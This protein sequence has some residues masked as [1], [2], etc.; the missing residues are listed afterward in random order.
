MLYN[1]GFRFSGSIQQYF[2]QPLDD[3]FIYFQY[4]KQLTHLQF[5]QYNDGDPVSTGATSYLWAVI[6]SIGYFFGFTGSWIIL[7][8]FLI[9]GLF[10]FLTG[11]LLLR[12]GIMIGNIKIGF[13]S[14]LL[15]ILH[16]PIL[17]GL[18]DGLETPLII[19]SFF[20]ALFV[21]LKEEQ[22]GESTYFWTILAGALL[23]L[24]RPEGLIMCAILYVYLLLRTYYKTKSFVSLVKHRI[25]INLILGSIIAFIPIILNLIFTGHISSNTAMSKAVGIYPQVNLYWK[26]QDLINYFFFE[27]KHIFAGYEGTKQDI[28]GNAYGDVTNYFAPYVFLIFILGAFTAMYKEIHNKQFGA[29]GLLAPWF[30]FY[31]II[32]AF[33]MPYNIHWNRYLIPTYP[34][35]FFGAALGACYLSQLSQR[36][37]MQSFIFPGI[38][39]FFLVVGGLNTISFAYT[40]GHNCQ[41]IFNQQ[42]R[43]SKWINENIPENS[44]IAINDAGA[45]KYYTNNYYMYDL[46]GLVTTRAIKPKIN[47]GG[48]VYESIESLPAEELPDYM[49]LLPHW[50]P[51]AFMQPHSEIWRNTLTNA[52]ISGNPLVM[53]KCNWNFLS[54][55][56]IPFPDTM[57][58]MGDYQLRDELDISD[59]NDEEKHQFRIAGPGKNEAYYNI[60]PDTQIRITEGGRECY[61]YIQFIVSNLVPDK[62]GYMVLRFYGRENRINLMNLAPP[63]GIDQEMADAFLLNYEDREMDEELEE[64]YEGYELDLELSDLIWESIYSGTQ[65][66]AYSG[67]N[68]MVV[69]ISAHHIWRDQLY[70]QI[71]NIGT[72]F[73]LCHIWVYQDL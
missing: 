14:G 50:Y 60:I 13:Y 65:S 2:S 1:T 28:P 68:E 40:F 36:E 70:L 5:F 23:S 32:K 21:Y 45:I 62:K 33:V 56:K 67:F 37:K 55:E 17:W 46:Q 54:T 58:S 64:K 6:L 57:Q 69:P 27:I 16:G 12:I 48:S 39:W 42:I 43:I 63:M 18:L 35:V 61:A 53:Y 24:A 15:I 9:A 52:S 51:Q 22:Q 49:N 59:L 3:S 8:V 26:V 30:L 19:L 66:I 47:G 10:I 41:E 34:L 71:H 72:V 25:I 20:I 4:A 11:E 73:I 7:F 31:I 44:R 38:L 29:L